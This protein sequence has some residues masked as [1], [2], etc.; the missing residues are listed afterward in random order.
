MVSK[1]LPS[2]N[3]TASPLS[4]THLPS[5]LD[6]KPTSFSFTQASLGWSGKECLDFTPNNLPI[7][8]IYVVLFQREVLV[9]QDFS[10]SYL[11]RRCLQPL[12]MVCSTNSLLEAFDSDQKIS[13]PLNHFLTYSHPPPNGHIP[14]FLEGF[15]GDPSLSLFWDLTSWLGPAVPA[16]G[17]V[18]PFPGKLRFPQY[19]EISE[20]LGL[21]GAWLIVG[22]HGCLGVEDVPAG[23]VWSSSCA[24]ASLS[25]YTDMERRGWSSVSLHPPLSSP[26]CRWH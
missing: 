25:P 6:S 12:E 19:Q 15:G 1:S 9:S 22:A 26:V 13:S 16:L 17:E 10:V 14:C 4:F 5:L 24:P 18:C 21:A 2:L 3:S 7:M 23:K 20:G 8:K 11:L